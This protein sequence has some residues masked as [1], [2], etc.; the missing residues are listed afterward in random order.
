MDL[1]LRKHRSGKENFKKPTT[2]S[3]RQCIISVF[4][5]EAKDIKGI[6]KFISQNQTDNVMAKNQKLTK[7]KQYTK[8]NIETKD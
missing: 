6:F 3:S 2:I 5:R 8:H 1:T 4:T 7:D